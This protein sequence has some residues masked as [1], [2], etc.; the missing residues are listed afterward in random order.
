MHIWTETPISAIW[1]QLRY[2]E[3]PA[4]VS[5]LLSGKTTSNRIKSEISVTKA[6]E[7]SA[8]ISACI[9]QAHSYFKAATA[10][11]Y[12]TKPLLLYYG[13]NALAKAL[14]YAHQPYMAIPSGAL[15]YHGLTSRERKQTGSDLHKKDSRLTGLEEEFAIVNDGLF[16]AACKSLGDK[17]PQKGSL[18]LLKDLMSRIPDIYKVYERHYGEYSNC[19]YIYGHEVKELED[20]KQ[21]VYFSPPEVKEKVLS[22]FPEFAKGFAACDKHGHTG[23]IGKGLLDI[24]RVESGT[25]AGSFFVKPHASGVYRTSSLMYAAMFILST[26]VRY[27]P[28]FWMKMIQGNENGAISLIEVLCDAFTR[29]FPN[30]ILELIWNER[31]TYGAPGYLS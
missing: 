19:V 2:P 16:A 28:S 25:I 14:I 26:T 20:G 12:T 15:Q 5:A 31:F 13:A 4:N 9:R 22:I 17:T 7:L 6:E 27:K 8:E 3:N 30:E 10:V 24:G 21:A 11:D 29:R 18:L 1:Q 23:Y